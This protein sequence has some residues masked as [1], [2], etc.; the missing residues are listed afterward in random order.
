MLQKGIPTIS[1]L[2]GTGMMLF[3]E[4]DFPNI[5]KIYWIVKQRLN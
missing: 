5:T 3:S 2:V 4:L 1:A